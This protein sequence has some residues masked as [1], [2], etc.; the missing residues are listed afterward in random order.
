[1]DELLHFD[2]VL[3]A[4]GSQPELA[5]QSEDLAQAQLAAAVAVEA[6]EQRRELLRGLLQLHRAHAADHGQH[7]LETQ[8]RALGTRAH[9]HVVLHGQV[10]F[11]RPRQEAVL[12]EQAPELGRVQPG[13]LGDSGTGEG[14]VQRD[15]LLAISHDLLHAQ[16]L[17]G[18][19]GAYTLADDAAV[20]LLHLRHHGLEALEA[21]CAA[22]RLPH[23]DIGLLECSPQLLQD[24][25]VEIPDAEPLEDGH[26]L[27]LVEHAGG[28][29]VAVGETLAQVA[30]AE[31]QEPLPEP[32]H[33]LASEC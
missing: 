18:C 28:V 19:Y 16:G 5:E 3:P 29:G 7:V 10:P 14:V 12:D 11:G 15:E 9:E 21:H 13:A 24:L 17:Q 25:P 22:P 4:L 2:L 1:M 8:S 6:T 33:G 31:L 32:R 27:L 30:P 20:V 23:G 26:A